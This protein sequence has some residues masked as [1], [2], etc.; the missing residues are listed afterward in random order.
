MTSHF[1]TNFQKGGEKIG[2]N[3]ET[4]PADMFVCINAVGCIVCLRML[5]YSPGHLP[6]RLQWLSGFRLVKVSQWWCQRAPALSLFLHHP[7]TWRASAHMGIWQSLN[8]TE[9]EIKWERENKGH[10]TETYPGFNLCVCALEENQWTQCLVFVWASAQIKNEITVLDY[11]HLSVKRTSPPSVCASP[12]DVS[13]KMLAK[14]DFV[15]Y[16]SFLK[17]T[18]LLL[19]QV[20]NSI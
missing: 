4:N 14:T 7:P 11:P 9:R 6:P 16:L 17:H 13:S 10:R 20:P 19:I 18:E 8:P 1:Q 3:R 15:F 5:T 12:V 2:H